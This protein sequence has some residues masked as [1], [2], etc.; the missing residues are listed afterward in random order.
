MKPGWYFHGHTACLRRGCPDLELGYQPEQP[1]ES[2]EALQATAVDLGDP[3]RD[4]YYG[5]G[6]VQ[7][8]D[9]W[10][11]LGGGKSGKPPK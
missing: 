2:G 10:L 1:A 5:Y 9:A 4:V 8:Y 11:H 6:L 3:G 7:A